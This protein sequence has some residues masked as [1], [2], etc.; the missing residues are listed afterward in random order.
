MVLLH[1]YI[2]A[3][4]NLTKLIRPY[5]M[6]RI[7]E[8]ERYATATEQIQRSVLD[9]ILSCGRKC[10]WGR[11]HGLASVNSY[12]DFAHTHPITDYHQLRPCI[13]KMIAGERDELWPG[14]T[15]RFAQSSGTSDGKSKF[16]PI[17]SDSLKLNH[18]K[19]G[20]DVI[21]HYLN[22]HPESRMF[23]GKAFILGGSFANELN[24]PRSSKTR[25]GDLSANLIE[26]INPIAN[27]ARIPSKEIA[28][29]PDWSS[30]LPALVEAAMDKD[31]TNISGVPSWF[32][33]VIKQIMERKGVKELHEVWPNLEVFFHGGISFAP[34]RELYNSIIDPSRMNYLETYNA[35]EGFFA[36]QDRPDS[37]S[38]LLLI[39]AGVFYEFMPINGGEPVPAWKVK[40]GEIYA[41]IITATNGLWRFPIGD[42]VR[43]ET[44]NPLRITIAGRTKCF[45]NAFGE[46]VMVH[47][48]DAALAKACKQTGCQVLNYTAAPVYTTDRSRGHH[49]WLIEFDTPPSDLEQFASL[50]DKLLTD[51]NS[52]Y[53]AKRAGNIFLDPL[54]VTV[55][56]PGL[57]DRWLASTGKLGGQRK[58]PRLTNDRHLIDA[59]LKFNN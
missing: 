39:D 5:F 36:I 49:Q 3:D 41:L 22:N 9:H 50:L 37:H 32:L 15:R 26:A 53:Q 19:G 14:V 18:Y 1:Y 2:N 55:A 16:I 12:E 57:F 7:Q 51:E 6:R 4:M 25:V 28:L 43:I 52:D 11:E 20:S 34:Y 56:S 10:R 17:T 33:T 27:L 38:M 24:I 21:S 31:V 44:V 35:S 23:D 13:M 42:T 46:E 48:T 59:M 29:M 47:N 40:Q 58:V 54:T 45:I 30:K 8:V